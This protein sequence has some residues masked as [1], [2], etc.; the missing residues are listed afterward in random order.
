MIK[1][2]I[3]K[4]EMIKKLISLFQT[5]TE[6]ITAQVANWTNTH[7]TSLWHKQ[8]ML[9]ALLSI[10]DTSI[11]MIMLFMTFLTCMLIH[12][13]S[14]TQDNYS[15]IIQSDRS[16]PFSTDNKPFAFLQTNIHMYC[17]YTS[18]H[19]ILRVN[20]GSHLLYF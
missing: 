4:Q 15:Q 2:E 5:E 13:V 6:E 3:T 18:H 16:V 17:L 7:E 1:I 9:M 8:M 20:W 19:A 10:N 14:F 12:A 11:I